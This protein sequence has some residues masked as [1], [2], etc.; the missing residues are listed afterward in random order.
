MLTSVKAGPFTIRGISVGGVYT[1]LHVPELDCLFD[2]G[3]VCR[4]ITGAS[5]ILVSHGHADHLGALPGVLGV[6][7]LL[8]QAPPRLFVPEKIAAPVRQLLQGFE[9]LQRYSLAVDLQPV[10]PGEVYELRRDLVVRVFRTHHT[11]PS[12]G[13]QLFRPVN[14]LKPEFVGL[15]GQ[16]IADRR[17]A[18]EEL[19]SRVERLEFAY[20]TDTLVR[21]L[22]THPSLLKTRV[23]VLECSFIDERKSLQES[24][25][26]CHIHL[27]EL[28]E[29]ADEFENEHVVLMHF[30]QMASPEEV[31]SV[32]KRR[33]PKS[34][35]ERLV[36]FAP[37]RGGWP[38]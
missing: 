26:G 5:N 3:T 16:E 9:Q 22:D 17:R 29:R 28:I 23:L 31:R 20:A 1:T 6:R 11:V 4:S 2:V 25:A 13:Y 38:G 10:Q 15:P 35:W 37:A 27:D 24:R 33:C 36:I 7:G 32:L 21:V 34:L 18:G 14:K 12:V 30:S 19:F 8:G